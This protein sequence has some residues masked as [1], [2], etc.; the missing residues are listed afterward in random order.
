MHNAFCSMAVER[1]QWFGANNENER[2]LVTLSGR[3]ENVDSLTR[4][5]FRVAI[6]VYHRVMGDGKVCLSFFFRGHFRC[7]YSMV[8]DE[9]K[10]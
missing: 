1:N 8:M 9:W 2:D 7:L 6:P 4:W 5:V 3:Y 10:S